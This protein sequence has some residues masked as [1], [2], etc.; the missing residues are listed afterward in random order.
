VAWT[1]REAQTVGTVERSSETAHREED[2]A[3]LQIHPDQQLDIFELQHRR[4]IAAAERRRLIRAHATA[5]ASPIPVATWLRRVWGSL[6]GARAHGAAAGP[7]GRRSGE[8]NPNLSAI[9]QE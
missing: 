7:V 8:A 3:M 4:D 1:G 9:G 5:T 6:V 2:Q